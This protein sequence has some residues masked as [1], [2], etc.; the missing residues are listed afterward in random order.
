MRRSH[1]WHAPLYDVCGGKHT[2]TIYFSHPM[3]TYGSRQAREW[4][5]LIEKHMKEGDTLIDPEELIVPSNYIGGVGEML[6]FVEQARKADIVICCT[7]NPE[8]LSNGIAL[9]A[10]QALKKV[11][12]YDN[13]FYDFKLE[14]TKII[15]KKPIDFSV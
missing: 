8:R 3:H 7:D 9:E 1:H 4:K 6:Y 11:L 12:L 13:T 2:T 10:N 5:K 14:G 15:E